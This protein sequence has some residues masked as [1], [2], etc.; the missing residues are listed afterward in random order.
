M[1]LVSGAWAQAGWLWAE[2]HQ[3]TA[4]HTLSMSLQTFGGQDISLAAL[5]S[6][7]CLTVLC[8][9]AQSLTGLWKCIV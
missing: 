1:L 4:A 6:Q 2:R 8:Q 7:Q 5:T 9:S 3:S